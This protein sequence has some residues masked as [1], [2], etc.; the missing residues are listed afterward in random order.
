MNLV[1]LISWVKYENHPNIVAIRN[2]N[3]NF[4]FH[5]NEISAEEVYKE[6][7]KLSPSKY[8]QSSDILI[9]VFKEN[10][11]IFADYDCGFFNEPIKILHFH[12]F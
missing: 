11:D 1:I 4:C 3:N 9:R 5:F 8:A 6:I 2:A 10:A 12:P 7:R